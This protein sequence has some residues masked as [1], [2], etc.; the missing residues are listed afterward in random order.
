MKTNERNKRVASKRSLFEKATQGTNY[1]SSKQ[2]LSNWTRQLKLTKKQPTKRFELFELQ[3]NSCYI[4]RSHQWPK[5]LSHVMSPSTRWP[6]RG[7]VRVYNACDIATLSNGVLHCFLF[8]Q[9]VPHHR[10]RELDPQKLQRD[11]DGELV[12]CNTQRYYTNEQIL[13]LEYFQ[14]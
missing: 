6:V 13:T 7:M 1:N 11:S 4:T 10:Q 9:S 8:N 12:D 2:A 14:I 5:Q 3:K